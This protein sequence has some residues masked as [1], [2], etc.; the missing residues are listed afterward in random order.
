VTPRESFLRA[1]ERRPHV[2]RVPTFEHV[3]FLTMDAF[4]RVHPAIDSTNSGTRGRNRCAACTFSTRHCVYAGLPLARYE[5]MPDVWRR[6]GNYGDN[7]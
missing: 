5:L 1:L 6:E 4:G 7:R 2:G 3:F